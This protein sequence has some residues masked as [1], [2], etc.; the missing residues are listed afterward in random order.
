MGDDGGEK[1]R[2]VVVLDLKRH[3]GI[4]PGR[5]WWTPETNPRPL[6]VSDRCGH[7]SPGRRRRWGWFSLMIRDLYA[8]SKEILLDSSGSRDLEIS[9][10]DSKPLNS[11][12][13]RVNPIGLAA[14]AGGAFN[15]K[16]K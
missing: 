14:T 8:D 7:E 5:A 10:R 1:R 6:S 16:P 2:G 3:T 9:G 13:G 15:R 12:A 4:L 11:M